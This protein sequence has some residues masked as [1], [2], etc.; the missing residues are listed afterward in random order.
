MNTPIRL[1][2]FVAGIVAALMMA[3]AVSGYELT[4]TAEDGRVLWRLPVRPLMSVVL[5][6]T[7]S[8]YGAATE[9]RFTAGSRGLELNSVA[10]TSES[11]LAYNALPAPYAKEGAYLVAETKRI[12]PALVVRIGQTGRQQLIVG[13]AVLPLYTAGTGA[14]VR[15]EVLRRRS[16]F[17]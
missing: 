4:I 5:T 2:L 13:D 7:N 17:R 14:Q 6:Y 8:I 9:E 15:I 12:I 10:S 1:I 16:I 11:V 3:A